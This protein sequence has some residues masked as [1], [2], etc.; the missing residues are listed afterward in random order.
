MS[1]REQIEKAEEDLDKACSEIGWEVDIVYE[2]D[3][4]SEIILEGKVRF[5]IEK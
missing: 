5:R 3:L 1:K 2:Q 4:G